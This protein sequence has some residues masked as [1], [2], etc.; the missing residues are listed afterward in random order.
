MEYGIV[1][2]ESENRL[3]PEAEI[4]KQ[5]PNLKEV[6]YKGKYLYIWNTY[7]KL[8]SAQRQLD[9]VM[10]RYNNAYIVKIDFI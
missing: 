3:S 1:I 9:N 4:Y 10:K 7:K 5:N 8:K 2:Y 6:R